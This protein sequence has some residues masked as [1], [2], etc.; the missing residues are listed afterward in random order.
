M[1]EIVNFYDKY[2]C[3]QTEI[4]G[5]LSSEYV[6]CGLLGCD[7]MTHHNPENHNRHIYEAFSY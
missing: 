1:C 5:S 7:T 3:L 4:W 2:M 6:T